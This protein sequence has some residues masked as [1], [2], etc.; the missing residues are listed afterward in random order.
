VKNYRETILNK[1]KSEWTK[2]RKFARTDL[3]QDTKKREKEEVMKVKE[4]IKGC[5]GDT[6]VLLENGTAF[7]IKQ[8]LVEKSGL[9]PDS[10]LE[11]IKTEK[12]S[13]LA[14]NGYILT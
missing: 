11:T 9:G 3:D 13:H 5:M 14:F 10:T 12:D 6:M 8:R 1:G 4:L 7:T 2:D